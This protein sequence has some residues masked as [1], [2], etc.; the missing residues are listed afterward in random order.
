M[1]DPTLCMNP[2]CP[3][4]GI[5][6]LNCFG[7]MTRDPTLCINPPAESGPREYKN[8]KVTNLIIHFANVNRY[9]PCSW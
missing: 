4:C 7:I 1:G 6:N 8:F 9:K 2:P 3:K 5:D